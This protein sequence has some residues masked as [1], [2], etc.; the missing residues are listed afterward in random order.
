MDKVR[1]PLS[2][3]PPISGSE[4]PSPSSIFL[5]SP[6]TFPKK[7]P[8]PFNPQLSRFVCSR[9]DTRQRPVSFYFSIIPDARP[10]QTWALSDAGYYYKE[11]ILGCHSLSLFRW[12]GMFSFTLTTRTWYS[13]GSIIRLCKYP[14]DKSKTLHLYK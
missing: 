13:K 14:K 8:V 11:E 2:F 5:S 3:L 9:A 4:D 1:L 10:W 6:T 12:E 7:R